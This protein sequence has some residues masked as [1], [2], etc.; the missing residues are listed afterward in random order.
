MLTFQI[1]LV[2]SESRAVSFI[3]NVSKLFLGAETFCQRA[4]LST[5]QKEVSTVQTITIVLKQ[6]VTQ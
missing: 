5:A 4:I 6:G 3:K 1:F 2:C